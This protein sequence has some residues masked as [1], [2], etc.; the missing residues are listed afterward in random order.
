MT[1]RPSGVSS[2][3][4]NGSRANSKID[5]GQVSYTAPLGLARPPACRYLSLLGLPRNGTRLRVPQLWEVGA[6]NE[7]FSR[8]G[9]ISAAY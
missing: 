5:Q 4:A 9:K 8:T 2:V 1:R 6:V 3:Y 7:T